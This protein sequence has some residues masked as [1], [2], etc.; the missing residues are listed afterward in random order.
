MG[1][2]LRFLFRFEFGFPHAHVNFRLFELR[3][4]SLSSRPQLC[5]P[6]KQTEFL[7]I[8]CIDLTCVELQIGLE[9]LEHL[10]EFQF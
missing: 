6:V 1:I 8:Q 9:L 3:V 4:E 2:K 7:V 10:S 5:F